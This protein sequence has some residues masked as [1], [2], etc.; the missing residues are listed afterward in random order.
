MKKITKALLVVSMSAALALPGVTTYASEKSSA[1]FDTSALTEQEKKE[2]E[3]DLLQIKELKD[4]KVNKT[5][6]EKN[7]KELE[8]VN[9]EKY[10]DIKKAQGIQVMTAGE[11]G[12]N[13]DILITYDNKTSGWRHG[14]AAIVQTNNDYVVESWPNVGVRSYK[15]N[16]SS[17]FSSKKKMYISGA[18]SSKYTAA[19][20]YAKSKIGSPY[21]APVGKNSPIAF[22]CSSLVWQSWY[23]QGYDLDGN[24]GLLVTPAD[25]E[26]DSQTIVY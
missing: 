23:K 26:N 22:Y 21:Q 3:N 11:M 9:P 7:L 17:R 5:E 12:T 15:N 4:K 25:L 19:Q 10:K 20:A 24:G 14:H 6:L 2:L 16:W 18:S 8:K 1:S 13:G